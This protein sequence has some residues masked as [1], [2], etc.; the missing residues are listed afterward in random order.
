MPSE[1]ETINEFIRSYASDIHTSIPAR[2][3]SYNPQQQTVDVVP[4]IDKKLS[5]GEVKQ[6]SALRNV[7]VHFIGSTDTIISY[8][9]KAGTCGVLIFQECSTDEWVTGS[10]GTSANSV[11]HDRRMHSATDAV[12]IPGI[13]PYSQSRSAKV[14]NSNPNEDLVVAHNL[15]G[16]Q[17]NVTFKA[18]GDIIAKRSGASFKLSNGL[19][20][21]DCNL[22]VNGTITATDTVTAPE[23][24]INSIPFTTHKHGGVTAGP[25]LTGNPQ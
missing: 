1:A 7:P 25:A 22:H 2:V 24:V 20:T 12:F 15:N 23:A 3:L 6:R 16:S 9:V 4:A 14:T 17:C 11:A 8:P 13:W 19:L 18:N 21:V 5:D 10:Q